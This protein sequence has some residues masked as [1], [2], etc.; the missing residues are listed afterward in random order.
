MRKLG[1]WKFSYQTNGFVH[2]NSLHYIIEI[3]LHYLLCFILIQLQI[4]FHLWSHGVRK[5]VLFFK[6]FCIFIFNVI[7][8]LNYTHLVF[9]FFSV[10]TLLYF[11]QKYLPVFIEYNFCIMRFN[12]QSC[13]YLSF[14]KVLICLFNF[15]LSPPCLTIQIVLSFCSLGSNLIVV[16][17]FIL[18]IIT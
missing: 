15:Y 1:V 16:Y 8:V 9:T 7:N 6:I 14:Q 18:L 5:N 2:Y 3:I 13:C 10:L 17:Y 12:L 11:I 4:T